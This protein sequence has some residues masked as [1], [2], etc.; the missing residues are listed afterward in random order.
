MNSAYK[1]N[2]AGVARDDA[3]V[4]GQK[5]SKSVNAGLQVV[6]GNGN[7][8]AATNF[9]NAST[10]SADKSAL[11]WGDN[12]GS[13]TAWTATGAPYLRQVVARK[14]RVQETGTVGSVKVQVAD[15]SGSNGLPTESTT[16][17]LLTDADGDFTTGAT[18]TAMTLN[19][20]N[21]EVNK[22]FMTGQ[23]FT[24]ATQ[25]TAPVDLNLSM[26]VNNSTVVP[27]GFAVCTYANQ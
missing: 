9:L 8:I 23:Y 27:G 14:W 18:E 7:I 1:N 11:I 2:I 5:Q 17:Y 12:A 20:N 16:V 13:V 25:N 4:L 3:S 26:T 24:F 15:D 21:W 10:F 19:G 6:V 22:D